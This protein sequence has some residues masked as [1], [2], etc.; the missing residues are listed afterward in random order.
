MQALELC[1]LGSGISHLLSALCTALTCG[2]SRF[3]FLSPGRTP[4]GPREVLLE[5]L[6]TDPFYSP[7]AQFG[8]RVLAV[9]SGSGADVYKRLL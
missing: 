1:H 8:G 9:G 7:R 6:S 5:Q 3:H 4:S 2:N